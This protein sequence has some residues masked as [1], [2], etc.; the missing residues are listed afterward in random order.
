MAP[1]QVGIYHLVQNS[2]S[3]ESLLALRDRTVQNCFRD[4]SAYILRQTHHDLVMNNLLLQMVSHV[5]LRVVQ[6]TTSKKLQQR[7]P[8]VDLQ[9]LG[10]DVVLLDQSGA[11]A[12]SRM[13]LLPGVE[14]R[15]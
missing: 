13:G 3:G 11:H 4:L 7:D 15:E 8:W 14:I 2:K 12:E 1:V 5:V 6:L 9:T 10:D